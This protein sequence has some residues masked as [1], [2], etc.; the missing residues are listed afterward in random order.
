MSLF[1]EWSTKMYYDIVKH[2][3]SVKV[4]EPMLQG[5]LSVPGIAG[6]AWVPARIGH[7]YKYKIF[8]S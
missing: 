8:F 2:R 4:I 6:Y 1:K 5:I 7:F 3:T